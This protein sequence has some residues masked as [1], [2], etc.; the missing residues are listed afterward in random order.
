MAGS[1][2]EG[3]GV[4][5]LVEVLP[6]VPQPFEA[7]RDR[8]EES[9]RTLEGQRAFARLIAELREKADIEIDEAALANDALW[10]AASPADTPRGAGASRR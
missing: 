10:R 7:V 5:E 8:V 4:V 3:F 1:E 2:S 9:W 6:A